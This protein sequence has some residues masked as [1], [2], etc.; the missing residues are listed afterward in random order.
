MAR[1]YDGKCM[2]VAMLVFALSLGSR[3][4]GEEFVSEECGFRFAIPDGFY[5]RVD[6]EPMF[7]ED[8]R[9]MTVALFTEDEATV[10][11]YMMT[12]HIQRL[13]EEIF[14]PFRP[15]DPNELPQREGLRLSVEKRTWQKIELQV[16][17][18]DAV[19]D[20]D[21][22]FVGYLIQFPLKGETIQIRVQGPKSREAEVL[23]TF[24]TSIESFVNT[25]TY[26]VSVKQISGWQ[27]W[28]FYPGVKFLIGC[29]LACVFGVMFVMVAK[30]SR[31]S[32]SNLA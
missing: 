22:A 14:D 31:R 30:L 1:R 21:E 5:E 11:G 18:Q 17:R 26:V 9:S 27:N 32:K 16:I 8:G 13:G 12:I 19:I 25:K 3:L 7:L 20:A 4:L 28:D 2:T 29:V 10:E 24:N 15:I 23:D 6:T